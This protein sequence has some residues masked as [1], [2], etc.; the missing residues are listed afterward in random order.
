MLAANAR[1]R[2]AWEIGR[3]SATRLDEVKDPT[4]DQGGQF[5]FSMSK[6]D[7]NKDP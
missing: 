7:D 1:R 2:S 4:P 3:L 5:G 6:T